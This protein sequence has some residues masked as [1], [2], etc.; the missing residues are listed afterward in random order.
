[1][2]VS[3]FAFVF[4]LLSLCVIAPNPHTHTHSPKTRLDFGQC[5]TA[6]GLDLGDLVL[7]L[8]DTQLRNEKQK[9]YG[10]MVSSLVDWLVGWVGARAGG[11]VAR[12]VSGE[13]QGTFQGSRPLCTESKGPEMQF[14]VFFWGEGA[15]FKY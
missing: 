12:L 11:W 3:V 7:F 10:P 5:V 13:F 15:A 8:C 2:F 6:P 4:V 9:E 1:M 14:F